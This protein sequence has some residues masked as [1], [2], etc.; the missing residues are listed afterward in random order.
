MT[1]R[2]SGL[3]RKQLQ[4]THYNQSSFSLHTFMRP[5]WF[6]T[7]DQRNVTV[8]LWVQVTTGQSLKK[9][10]ESRLEICSRGHTHESRGHCDLD[11]W[12]P[13]F[14][15]LIWR[16]KWIFEPI[17]KEL[18]R[19]VE[20]ITH[21]Q[22]QKGF[23]EVTMTLT[24]ELQPPNWRHQGDPEMVCVHFT[25]QHF[26]SSFSPTEHLYQIWRNSLKVLL[27]YHVHKSWTNNL[28]TNCLR[29]LPVTGS[30]EE[31]K[32]CHICKKLTTHTH[33]LSLTFKAPGFHRHA[34][35]SCLDLAPIHWNCW[36]LT[37]ETWHYVSAAWKRNQREKQSHTEGQ[38]QTGHRLKNKKPPFKLFLCSFH[39]K[40]G[41]KK[42]ECLI[43]CWPWITL[44]VKWDMFLAVTNPQRITTR[45]SWLFLATRHS[46]PEFL[47]NT[48]ETANVYFLFC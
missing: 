13:K 19:V 15:Q 28:R 26:S 48:S 10:P 38:I 17:L 23:C 24:F 16:S 35:V 31:N 11:L 43:L 25:Q 29:P 40:R 12:E 3:N 7:L 2:G 5:P 20:K 1:A 47:R 6:L 27:R 32:E 18:S 41:K 36:V 9:F 4:L 46:R 37:H 44:D 14:N 21:S 30:E 8:H 45:L 33:T 34:E 22:G 42:S 39:F